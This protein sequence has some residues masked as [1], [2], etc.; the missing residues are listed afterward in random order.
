[1]I[2]F[3]D[4][5]AMDFKLPSSTGYRAYWKEHLEFL[6]IASR[7]KVFVKAVITTDTKKND[8]EEAVKLIRTVNKNIPF[9]MQPA[10]PVKS[11][12]KKVCPSRLLEFIDIALKSEVE[13]SRV[14]PQMHKML[15]LK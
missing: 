13:N 12:D 1:V 15:G 9:I 6:K 11:F 10:S 4:I 7:K 5:V 3:I 14:I 2:D 8:I